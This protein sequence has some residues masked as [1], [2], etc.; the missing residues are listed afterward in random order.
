MKLTT[1]GR[2][3]L[4]AVV[5]LAL[6]NG[7]SPVSIKSIAEQ[8][9]ISPI[10]LEQIFYLLKKR[11]LIASVRGPGGGFILKKPSSEITL[12]DVLQAVGESVY[13][14][15]CTGNEDAKLACSRTASCRMTR[16]WREFHNLIDD[17]LTKITLQDILTRSDNTE[18]TS[19]V[20][21]V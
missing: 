9:G 10:F 15:P 5:Q 20:I 14:V 13:I 16:I 2:Y 6:A 7:N 8:E 21:S 17:Y 4:R 18:N 11:G 3:G 1:K 12:K 19:D